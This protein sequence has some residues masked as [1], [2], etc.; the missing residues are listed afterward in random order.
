MD[1]K[2]LFDPINPGEE[3]TFELDFSNYLDIAGGEL[4]ST[5]AWVC[6][7]RSGVDASAG[8][9]ISGASTISGDSLRTQQFVKNFITA[10]AGVVYILAATVVTNRGNKKTLYAALPC[11]AIA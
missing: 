8:G 9:H 7:I 4:I 6:T 3:E 11:E 2:N 5:A 10:N 1:V